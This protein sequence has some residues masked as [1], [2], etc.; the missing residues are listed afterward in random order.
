MKARVR[1]DKTKKTDEKSTKCN[2]AHTVQNDPKQ[3]NPTSWNVTKMPALRQ[4]LASTANNSGQLLAPP[5]KETPQHHTPEPLQCRLRG[6]A[7]PR[8]C[9]AKSNKAPY[10]SDLFF[11]GCSLVEQGVTLPDPAREILKQPDPTRPDPIRAEP[12]RADQTRRGP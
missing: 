10:A 8:A 3:I 4:T 12:N 1:R 6:R 7:Q 9:S 2:Y 5:V 11:Q